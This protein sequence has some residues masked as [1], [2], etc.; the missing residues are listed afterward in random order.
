M[1]VLGYR[2][3]SPSSNPRAVAGKF[4]CVRRVSRIL[5]RVQRCAQ[6]FSIGLQLFAYSCLLV[7]RENSAERLR[8]DFLGT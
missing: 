7:S 1:L 5:L 8:Y 6:K 2:P 4:F 3:C